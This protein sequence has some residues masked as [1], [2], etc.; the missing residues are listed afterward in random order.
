MSDKHFINGVMC[1]PGRGLALG[2]VIGSTL[3]TGCST[4][5]QFVNYKESRLYSSDTVGAVS[6]VEVG[7][8]AEKARGYIWTSCEKVVGKVLEKVQSELDTHA[9]NATIGVEWV[10]HAE[11]TS[12]VQPLCTTGWGWFGLAGVGGWGPWVKQA[13]LRGK[14]VFADQG[15]LDA[16]HGQANSYASVLEAKRQAEAELAV[17]MEMQEQAAKE[18]A[19]QAKRDKKKNKDKDQQASMEEEMVERLAE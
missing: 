4:S 12:G 18:A 17:G 16:L 6:Y 2:L 15:Q 5:P 9:G 7:P 19:K 8:V 1:M 14:L 11:G 10:N 13:E 3:A